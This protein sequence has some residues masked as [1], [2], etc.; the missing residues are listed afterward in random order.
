MTLHRN[1]LEPDNGELT[2]STRLNPSLAVLLTLWTEND[3][4]ALDLGS[5]AVTD[6]TCSAQMAIAEELAS[7]NINIRANLRSTSSALCM[8]AIF[9]IGR[10][11]HSCHR[12][13]RCL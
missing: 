1:P 5:F 12:P 13:P 4:A 3:A 6:S 8:S 2:Q 10:V 9:G 11:S 7:C